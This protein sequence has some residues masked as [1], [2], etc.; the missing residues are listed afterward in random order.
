M[1][2]FFNR[3]IRS[4]PGVLTGGAG[5]AAI[6]SAF[7]PV[8][9][10]IGGGVGL[11]GGGLLNLL[12]DL[13][14]KTQQTSRYTPQQQSVMNILLQRAVRD[15][16]PKA[17]ED[18]YTKQFYNQTIPNIGNQFTSLGSGLSSSNFQ[19]SLG[20]AGANLA[21]KLA[22]IRSGEG[23]KALQ[24]GMQQQ[25]DTQYFPGQPGLEGAGGENLGAIL[26]FLGKGGFSGMGKGNQ[27]QQA[28]GQYAPGQ[29]Q[30]VSG[31]QPFVSWLKSMV[32]KIGL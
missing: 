12:A 31:V 14:P 6:G 20:N 25:F 27:Q 18:M 24:F 28:G 30:G 1:N 32:G 11:L 10:A 9:T 17:L 15:T 7:G 5:G 8:G 19:A 22:A 4:I 23:M 26:G 16:D 29:P 13:G 2:K 3:I 21:A